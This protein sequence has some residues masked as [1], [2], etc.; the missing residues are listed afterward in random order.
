MNRKILVLDIDGT[1][2]NDKKE[3]TPK[4]KSGCFAIPI[5][6]TSSFCIVIF[7]CNHVTF[8]DRCSIL[9]FQSSEHTNC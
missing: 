6:S 9:I 5:N 1:L 8:I 7:V 2:V 3:I 4:T